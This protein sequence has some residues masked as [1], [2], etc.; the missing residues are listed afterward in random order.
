METLDN[1]I[2]LRR[3]SN[4]VVNDMLENMKFDKIDDNYKYLVKMPMDSVTTENVENIV[5]EKADTEK[6]LSILKSTSL[7][8]MWNNELD[9]FEKEYEKYKTYRIKLQTVEQEKIKSPKK[10][11]NQI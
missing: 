5:K 2:D 3:K 8:K 1:K 7:E 6:E 10:L 9:E 4:A 11:Q